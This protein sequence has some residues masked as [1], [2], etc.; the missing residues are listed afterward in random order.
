[1]GRALVLSFIAI[2]LNVVAAQ[3]KVSTPWLLTLLV[4]ALI[5]SIVME[6]SKVDKES[7][8]ARI[9]I[10]PPASWL[11]LLVWALVSALIGVVVSFIALLLPYPHTQTS[12]F[13]FG[14]LGGSAV[15]WYWYDV[16]SAA[17]ISALP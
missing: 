13:L 1:V 5:G 2:V 14:G 10:E 15:E 6:A 16:L 4:L 9:N 8:R 17:A 11:Q 7:K 12:I 3:I